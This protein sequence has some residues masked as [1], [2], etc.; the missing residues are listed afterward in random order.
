MK[1]TKK[2]F[3]MLLTMLMALV[4]VI[5]AFAAGNTYTI[6]INNST[7]GHTYEAYQ[8]FAG[9]LSSNGKILSNITWGDGVNED[10]LLTALKSDKT[11]GT[12][13]ADCG[14]AADVAAV[15]DDFGN[16]S[17][18]LDA[19]AAVVGNNLSDTKTFSTEGTGSYSISDLA[20]GY[21]FVK[22]SDN[23]NITGNDAYTKFMLKLVN[24][25]TVTL[26]SDVPTVEKKVQEDDKYKQD[27]DYGNGYNDVAD[28]NIGDN[29]PFKLI[30]T[31]PE[32]DGYDTYKY[33]F[34]DTMSKGLT[35]NEDSIQVYVVNAK[36]TSLDSAKA[37]TVNEDYT[38]TTSAL[39]DKCSFEVSFADLKKVEGATKG[40]YIIVSYTA[41][42]NENAEIGL[43]GN[44]NEVYLEFS[45]NPAESGEGDTDNTGKT[46]ED[47]VIVFTYEL[48]TTKVDGTNTNI[49]LKDAEFVLLNKDGNK[50]ANVDS[51]T[52]KFKGWVD[53]PSGTGTN[54]E[55]VYSD[56]TEKNETTNVILK[57]DDNGL[58]KVIGLDDGDYKLRE[59]KAPDG[60]NLLT[61]DV[62]VKITATTTNGQNWTDGK[63][64]NALTKLEV[65]VDKE[66]GTG[67]VDDG[68]A[69]INIANNKGPTLPETGG[70]GTTIFYVVGGILVV[71][72]GVMLI[73]RR[74]MNLTDSDK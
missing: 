5:P 4:M 13:F 65:V 71:A 41:I 11:I 54:S 53:L 16:D 52:G 2:L 29:V 19:F 43:P 58:F 36:N 34:H 3:A 64:E 61:K 38:L 46:P 37:L 15:L 44:P 23:S 12:R 74:R 32:M 6:T 26:K 48:D 30:G 24:S 51:T 67:N 45:N 70:M 73:T 68:T 25:I 9:D 59:I 28:W 18:Q 72:A 47:K 7:S 27:G 22:D 57:S 39:S 40:S 8:V 35:L 31:I 49:T 33:I 42:L 50:V 62:D 17:V 21:Y 14:T 66:Q 56:W 55:I 1:A 10:T 63:A 60:Y 69:A 20:A